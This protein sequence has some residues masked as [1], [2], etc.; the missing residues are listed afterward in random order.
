MVDLRLTKPLYW[1][2]FADGSGSWV[3]S[4]QRPPGE[5][6]AAMRQGADREPG[7]V[8][9]LWPHH[10]VALD[11]DWLVRHRHTWSLPPAFQAEHHALTL[12]GFHQQSV[13]EP[14]H[15]TGMGLG[16]AAQQFRNSGHASEAAVDRLFKAVAT[17]TTVTELAQHLRRLVTQL[18]G[19]RVPLDYRRLLE[20]LTLWHSPAWQGRVRRRWGLDYYV[21]RARPE[22]TDADRADDD[23]PAGA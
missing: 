9:G 21:S 18:R 7:T 4:D 16:L 5:D 12:Y 23:Q 11:D 13:T 8:P 22:E 6:L 17:A 20:E 14:M 1:E 15:R 19:V 2:R 3:R 10:A